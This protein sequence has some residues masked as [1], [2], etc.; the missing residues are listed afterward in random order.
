[1]RKVKEF[2][3]RTKGDLEWFMHEL[4]KMC[5]VL[6]KDKMPVLL[7]STHAPPGFKETKY[8]YITSPSRVYNPYERC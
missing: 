2:K 1:M 4:R 6:W 8:P 7:L 5:S 3:R